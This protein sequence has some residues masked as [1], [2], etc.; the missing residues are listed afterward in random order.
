[1]QDGL[2]NDPNS[3]WTVLVAALGVPV[4]LM[5]AGGAGGGGGLRGGGRGWGNGDHSNG[6][7][8]GG[9]ALPSVV[10]EIRLFLIRCLLLV[11]AG[12]S[13]ASRYI[14]GALL[15]VAV[16]GARGG[17]GGRPRRAATDCV[18]NAEGLQDHAPRSAVQQMDPGSP[19]VRANDAEVDEDFFEL[20]MPP[21]PLAQVRHR[22]AFSFTCGIYSLSSLKLHE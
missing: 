18:T 12:E 22:I 14:R 20:P 3:A 16:A 4:A 6:G 8:G 13:A 19:S 7:G 5:G 10:E 2:P 17:A 1:M 21:R 9:G 15:A 11:L